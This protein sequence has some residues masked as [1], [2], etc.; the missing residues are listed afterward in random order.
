MFITCVCVC[1]TERETEST[2]SQ[3]HPCR[4]RGQ[5]VEL[6]SDFE[7][8]LPGSV[9][10]MFDSSPQLWYCPFFMPALVI[11][12][13]MGHWHVYIAKGHQENWFSVSPN[14]EFKPLSDFDSTIVQYYSK[15]G[16]ITW[17]ERFSKLSTVVNVIS[18]FV[19]FP[20]EESLRSGWLL[21]LVIFIFNNRNIS[22]LIKNFWQK[23][24]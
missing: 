5:F 13:S 6:N 16:F 23:D 18:P 3:G 7:L 19:S 9:A 11:P 20:L 24:R 10:S 1:E 14:S 4:S 21:F 15:V 12:T 17:K 8:R 2:C 22:S